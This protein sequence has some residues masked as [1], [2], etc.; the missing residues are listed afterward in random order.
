MSKQITTVL[1]DDSDREA[2]ETL[3]YQYR[4]GSNSAVMRLALRYLYE[5]SP[6]L[7]WERIQELQA[8]EWEIQ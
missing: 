6:E 8:E 4:Q 1:L 5:E 2:I 7:S 3:K